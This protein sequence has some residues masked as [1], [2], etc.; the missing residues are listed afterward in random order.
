M[1]CRHLAGGACSLAYTYIFACCMMRVS[2]LKPKEGLTFWIIVAYR[3]SCRDSSP[4][5]KQYTADGWL[6][7]WQAFGGMLLNGSCIANNTHP[8]TRARSRTLSS[9]CEVSAWDAW[10]TCSQGANQK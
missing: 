3:G 1:V 5:R 10:S 7:L 4:N 9:Q 2:T 6:H 8:R